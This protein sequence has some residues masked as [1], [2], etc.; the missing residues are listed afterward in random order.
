[1]AD[2]IERETQDNIDR[3]MPAA[4]AR[5]AALR[6]FGNPARMKEEARKVWSVVWLEHLLQDVHFGLRMLGKSPLFTVVAVVTLALGIGANTAIF[7]IVN[8]VLL[9]PLPFHDPSQ[10]VMLHEGIP[11]IGYPRMAFTAPDFMLF[12]REQK[13]FS[14]VGAFRNENVEVSGHSRS[15]RVTATRV[16][17]SLFPML[18]VSPLLGRNFSPEE[19]VPG[20]H[21]VL[22]SH[23]FWERR[24]GGD[25]NVL[26][27]ILDIN[28]E[29]HSIVGVMKEEFEFPLIGPDENA[30]PAD[31][32]IPMAFTATDLQDWGGS[33]FNTVLGRLRPGVTL[34]QAR[35]ETALVAQS[36]AGAYPAALSKLF[37]GKMGL[38]ITVSP[39]REEVVGSVRKLLMIL[40]GAVV[41]VLLISCANIAT[42]LISRAT[43][44]QKEISV[45]AAL[46]A[47]RLRV[48]RQLLTESLLLGG[49][50]GGLGIVV[51]LFARNLLLARIPSSISVPH[52]IPLDPRVFGFAAGV[53]VISAI[54]FGVSP[55]FPASASGVQGGLQESGRGTT[56]GRSHHRLQ[57]T[58]VA[59]EYALALV[60]LVGAGLLIRSYSKLLQTE[61]GIRAE[62][63]LTLN[64]PLPRQAYSKASQT[65]N[66][67]EPVLERVANL[68]GVQHAGLS[69]DLPLDAR[70]LVSMK[71][72]GVVDSR[73]AGVHAV[74]Q[75]WVMGN[76]FQVM[77]VPLLQGR[78]FSPQGLA[79]AEPVAIVSL[80]T[81]KKYWPGESALGKRVLWG[82]GDAWNRIVGVVGDVKEGPL[83]T[84]LMPHVYRPYLQMSGSLLE[85]DPFS[86][87]HAMNLAIHT[88]S[89]PYLLVSSVLASIHNLDPDLAF[90]DV[91]TMRTAIRSS[92]DGPEF[93]TVLLGIAGGVGA[94]SFGH[95]NLWR[96]GLRSGATDT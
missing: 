69:S 39:F 17:S 3:G 34:E 96:P 51:A 24:F 82:A 31:L 26:G 76:Y 86:E 89:D 37:S 8:G 9:R 75:S 56:A 54:I 71:F 10:L 41:F 95:W 46:G 58:F 4:E 1:M 28:R 79:S 72:D 55:A 11:S 18:K 25:T 32:W 74:S 66:F 22:L 30:T 44:R 52:H 14:A 91:R 47:T 35:S 63:V 70:E 38:N 13:S 92:V 49:I 64:I 61:S 84:P 67:Y 40:M 93:N 19:D 42:L 50:G 7:S 59:I 73:N 85:V 15:E 23:A 21:V 12:T 57:G 94:V 81:A 43:V 68:P 45:R 78:V 53:S 65:Q 20:V 33:Y 77:G 2:H 6:K 88:E 80:S 36:V 62:G 83:N 87:F 48:L 27:Q 16:T 90:R 60:L 5:F 29:P